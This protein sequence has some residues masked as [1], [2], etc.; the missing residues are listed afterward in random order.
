MTKDEI[1][2]VLD[3]KYECYILIGQEEEFNETDLYLNAYSMGI[4]SL[5]EGAFKKYS[6][7]KRIIKGMVCDSQAKHQNKFN[8]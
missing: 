4:M 1:K 5:L 8:Q 6:P 2:K 3:E 7:L